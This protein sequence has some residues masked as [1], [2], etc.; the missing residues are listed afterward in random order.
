MVAWR[1]RQKEIIY[2]FNSVPRGTINSA[3]NSKIS[4]HLIQVAD[5]LVALHLSYRERSCTVG[6]FVLSDYVM[7]VS[8]VRIPNGTGR[9]HG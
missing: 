2:K 4:P 5:E 3:K 8:I 1:G 9:R 7:S 6:V